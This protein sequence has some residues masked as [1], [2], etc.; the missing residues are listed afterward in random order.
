M[1]GKPPYDDPRYI[2]AIH[3]VWGVPEPPPAVAPLPPSSGWV[4][5]L[6]GQ[7]G[8]GTI[9]GFKVTIAVPEQGEP[10]VSI[11]PPLPPKPPFIIVYVSRHSDKS[12]TFSISLRGADGLYRQ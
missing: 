5:V 1:Y 4:T 8:E 2:V 6:P 11:D 9:D 7:R 10:D 3:A 12:A